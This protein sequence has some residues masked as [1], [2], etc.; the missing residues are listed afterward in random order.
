[1]EGEWDWIAK[2]DSPVRSMINLGVNVLLV[3]MVIWAAMDFNGFR[4]EV[5]CKAWQP[6]IDI[7]KT[8]PHGVRSDMCFNPIPYANFTPVGVINGSMV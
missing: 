3:M 6:V 5:E 8:C 1:M 2:R 4:L 7:A